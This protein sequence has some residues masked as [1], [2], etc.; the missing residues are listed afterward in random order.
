[1][2]L[3]VLALLMTIP[4]N[5]AAAPATGPAGEEYRLVWADEFNKDGPL[6]QEDWG[7][8]RGFVRNQELQWYQPDNAVCKDGFLMIEARRESKPNP[9]YVAPTTQPSTA[10]SRPRRGDGNAWK[11]RPTIEYTSASVN[12]R[13]KHTWLYGRFEIRAKIDVRAG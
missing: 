1:S 13:G 11:N 10:P 7:F 12:T 4:S 9:R 6:D 2:I 8:E 3:F 5:S